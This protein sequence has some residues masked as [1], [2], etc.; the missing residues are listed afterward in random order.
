MD[1]N[2]MHAIIQNNPEDP[3]SLSWQE[4]PLPELKE[5]EALVEL[6]FAGLNLSLIHI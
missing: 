5:G 3:S 4:A 2:T 1:N 6:R